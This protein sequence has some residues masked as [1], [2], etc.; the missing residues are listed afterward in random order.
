MAKK[1]SERKRRA[2]Q[3]PV[4]KEEPRSVTVCR[5][6]NCGRLTSNLKG[7]CTACLT[8][9]DPARSPTPLRSRRKRI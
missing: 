7:L 3:P 5:G 9:S 4:Y 2:G 6:D 1:G 8:L